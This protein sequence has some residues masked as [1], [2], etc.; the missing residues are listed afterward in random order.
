M[1]PISCPETSV[2]NYHYSLRYNPEERIAHLLC[3]GSLKSRLV[4]VDTIVC[5]ECE[6]VYLIASCQNPSKPHKAL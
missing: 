4:L 6:K 1:G 5:K 2:I 3:G